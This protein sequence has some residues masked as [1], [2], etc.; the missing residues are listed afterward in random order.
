MDNPNKV[1]ILQSGCA[2]GMGSF[3]SS[4]FDQRLG[5]FMTGE[6]F[7]STIEKCN[8]TLSMAQ[9]KHG[10]VCIALIVFV[11]ILGGVSVAFSQMH[12][13]EIVSCGATSGLECDD[14]TAWDQAVD[15]D[16]CIWTCCGGRLSECTRIDK[17]DDTTCNAVQD[18]SGSSPCSV[19]I[20]GPL[21]IT[22]EENP[23]A[24]NI[25]GACA[26]I[27]V[28]CCVG[29]FFQWF[30]AKRTLKG[31]MN[32]NF[33]VWRSKGLSAEYFAGSKHYK[34][35]IVVYLPQSADLPPVAWGDP[36]IAG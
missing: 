35:R 13:P 23:Q 29:N 16:C 2:C 32:K 30:A 10:F 27:G 1:D 4:D 7:E 15:S 14:G 12:T 24:G 26:L 11:V 3:S 36:S 28:L 20:E 17:T 19:T 22:P 31:H 25:S 9:K 8:D 18:C 5:K 21:D 33:D 6:E 34:A